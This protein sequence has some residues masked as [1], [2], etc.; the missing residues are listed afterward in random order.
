[1]PSHVPI[2]LLRRGKFRLCEAD[3]RG[4]HR[5]INQVIGDCPIKVAAE[6]IS[7]RAADLH[8]GPIPGSAEFLDPRHPQSLCQRARVRRAEQDRLIQNFIASQPQ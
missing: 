3:G 4:V 2:R 1:M 6:L 5:T 7:I 8:V